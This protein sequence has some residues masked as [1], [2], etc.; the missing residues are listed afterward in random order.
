MYRS[1]RPLE[2]LA[3][4]LLFESYG[5]DR[6]GRSSEDYAR[7]SALVPSLKEAHFRVNER[8]QQENSSGQQRWRS[9]CRFKAGDISPRYEPFPTSISIDTIRNALNYS[10]F[11]VAKWQ[12]PARL[13]L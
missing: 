3:L 4:D 13:G 8:L 1:P 2:E 10:G 9:I 6:Y 12:K 7:L 5:E 11:R